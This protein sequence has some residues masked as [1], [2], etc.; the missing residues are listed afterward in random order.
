MN[1]AARTLAQGSLF[2]GDYH[3]LAITR[4]WLLI[5]ILAVVVLCSAMAVV[6]VKNTERSVFSDL[7]SARRD[8]SHLQV[9]WGQLLLERSTLATPAR[10]QKIAQSKLGMSLPN[11]KNVEIIRQ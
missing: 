7:Q 8:A 4:E 6:Y 11:P 3:R 10:V 2:R 5:T 9:E 1:A